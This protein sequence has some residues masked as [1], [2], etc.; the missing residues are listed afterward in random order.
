MPADEHRTLAESAHGSVPVAIVTISDTRTADTD[1][2]GQL[3]RALLEEKGHSVASYHLLKDEPSAIRAL[4]VYLTAPDH[5]CKIIICNGGTGISQRDTT[6]DVLASL[7]EKTLPGFGE[8]FR[9]L[10]YAEIGAAAAFSRA[11][12]GVYRGRVIFSLPGS[13][14]A[15]RLGLEKLI[16]PEIRHYAWE[17]AR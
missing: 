17:V 15:V 1:Q 3:I 13:P 10:S 12:A 16:L 7:L 2:S 4:L 9:M 14:H 5:P 6:Y 11:T 8:L